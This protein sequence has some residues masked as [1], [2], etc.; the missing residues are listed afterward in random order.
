MDGGVIPQKQ[1]VSLVCLYVWVGVG[2][3]LIIAVRA[4]D[5]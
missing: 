4:I 1:R 2:V 3:D 5:Y